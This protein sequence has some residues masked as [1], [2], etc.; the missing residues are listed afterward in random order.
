MRCAHQVG[1]PASID[2]LIRSVRQLVLLERPMPRRVGI[3]DWAW[4]TGERYGTAVI[5]L[6]TPHPVDL[7]PDRCADTLVAWLMAYPGI[8]LIARD[9]RSAYADGAARPRRSR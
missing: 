9:R 2:V 8:E 3:D 4:R 1:M 6:D 7:L 5:D